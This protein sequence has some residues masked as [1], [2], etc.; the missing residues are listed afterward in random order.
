M[1][2]FN[3]LNFSQI[4]LNTNNNKK[5]INNIDNNDNNDNQNNKIN[6][7][8]IFYNKEIKF[9]NPLENIN[10]IIQY[11]NNDEKIIENENNDK[12]EIKNINNVKINESKNYNNNFFEDI[13]KEKLNFIKENNIFS[14]FNLSSKVDK[15]NINLES[16]N[17]INNNTSNILKN[18]NNFSEN[19]QE[20]EQK[21]IKKNLIKECFNKLF[22][23]YSDYSNDYYKLF[24]LCSEIFEFYI[25]SKKN[26]LIFSNELIFKNINY[27]EIEVKFFNENNEQFKNSYLTNFEKI[28]ND[29]FDN[30]KIILKI[31]TLISE[32]IKNLQD[33]NSL[34]SEIIQI[35]YNN[36][37]KYI[38]Q[39]QKE[40]KNNKYKKNN[41]GILYFNENKFYFGIFNDDK[42]KEGILFQN[43][44]IIITKNINFEVGNFYGLFLT[45]EFICC[46]NGNLKNNKLEGIYIKKQI[47]NENLSITYSNKKL[48]FLLKYYYINNLHNFYYKININ[49]YSYFCKFNNWI[50]KLDNNKNISTAFYLKNEEK[51][52][53]TG[54]V[55]IPDNKNMSIENVKNSD[56]DILYPI[57]DK[58]IIIYPNGHLYKGNVLKEN[59]LIKNGAGTYFIKNLDIIID[60]NFVNDFVINGKLF[61]KNEKYFEGKFENNLIKNGKIVD[62]KRNERIFEGGLNENL[63]YHGNN[64]FFEANNLKCIGNFENGKKQGNFTILNEENETEY[65]NIIFKDDKL[66]KIY[67][68]NLII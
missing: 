10:K 43:D 56:N 57:N 47:I 51:F 16:S 8:N 37:V 4:Q 58:S 44:K 17:I 6:I 22:D 25:K 20:N 53:I 54:N 49:N 2:S 21:E 41:N 26:L 24:E 63:E 45:N 52:P 7:N 9:I 31:K 34:N 30:K 40:N 36:N 64:I 11:V 3:T 32:L 38:G 46:G 15:N 19:L 28:K 60:G 55:K 35:N 12:N 5:S 61:Y 1:I 42:L 48:N 18:E 27:N 50:I 67:I 29:I 14:N 68:K 13:K 23:F 39:Y 65:K 62:I 66:E 33:E 59:Y